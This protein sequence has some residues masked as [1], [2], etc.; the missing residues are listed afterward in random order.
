MGC[1]RSGDKSSEK[2]SD[3]GR[4]PKE[5]TDMRTG[6]C[7][8]FRCRFCNQEYFNAQGSVQKYAASH[9]GQILILITIGCSC[10]CWI[11]FVKDKTDIRDQNFLIVKTIY[12]EC[13]IFSLG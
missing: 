3:V 12:K 2:E 1:G 6:C 9:I 10:R 7:A 4:L 8:S 13:Q 11:F 5:T